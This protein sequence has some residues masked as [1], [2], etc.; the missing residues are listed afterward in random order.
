MYDIFISLMNIEKSDI[1][2]EVATVSAV[3]KRVREILQVEELVEIREF[4]IHK[5]HAAAN[6]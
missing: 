2:D 3:K 4:L 5:A 1:K 6:K